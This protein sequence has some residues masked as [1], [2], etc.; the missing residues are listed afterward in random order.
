[1]KW[2][3]CMLVIN[4]VAVAC[5]AG[6][7]PTSVPAPSM[8]ATPGEG[9]QVMTMTISSSAFEN[10]KAIPVKYTCDGQNVSVP[11]QWSDPP[12]AAKSQALIVDDPDAPGG[13]FVHWVLYNLPPAARE[14]PE[15]VK[16]DPTLP[17][18]SRNGSNGAGRS[19]Y[20]GPCP[21][22]GTHHYFFKLYALDAMLSLATGA[23]KDQLLKAMQGRILAQ[24]QVMGTYSRK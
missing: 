19:G 24:A 17:D 1:M 20:M 16:T 2:F 22:S 23:T 18:G 14:L 6:S 10:G 12:T 3:A 5:V 13:M 9:G 7:A 21:P 4:L 8:S 15:G 11:L